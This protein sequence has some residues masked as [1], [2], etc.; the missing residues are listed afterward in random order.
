MCKFK[1]KKIGRESKKVSQ[2]NAGRRVSE[3]G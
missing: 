3:K 2:S 1:E